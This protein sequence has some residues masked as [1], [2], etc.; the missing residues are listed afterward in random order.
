MRIEKYERLLVI[1]FLFLLSATLLSAQTG[2]GALRGQVTDPSGAAISGASVI[3]TPPTG[4]PVVVQTNGQ[5][6][7]EFKSLPAGKYTLTIAAPGFSLYENDNV[8][9]AD[10]PL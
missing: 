8:V 7:Y 5:G 1:I 10:Q 6:T 9:I 4:S 3:M 2:S